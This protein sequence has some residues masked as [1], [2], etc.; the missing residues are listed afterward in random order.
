MY[1]FNIY[2]ALMSLLLFL[3]TAEG[4]R[5]LGYHRLGSVRY[6]GGWGTNGTGGGGGGGTDRMR[7]G[8]DPLNLSSSVPE[9]K[10]QPK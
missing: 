4:V 1:V 8:S 2:P 5:M 6:R 10:E 7:S 9:T 3:F